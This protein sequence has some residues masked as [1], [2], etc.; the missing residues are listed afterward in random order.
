[1]KQPITKISNIITRVI[2]EINTKAEYSKWQKLLLMAFRYTY[3]PCSRLLLSSM[4]KRKARIIFEEVDKYNKVFYIIFRK[5]L[6][7][8]L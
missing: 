3:Y 5:Y 1:M 6:I 4:R 7:F 2:K 8:N